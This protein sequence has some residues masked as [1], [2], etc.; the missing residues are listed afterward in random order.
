M[1][2]SE[3]LQPF[4]QMLERCPLFY[5]IPKE[6][7]EPAL[8]CMDAQ[9]CHVKKGQTILTYGD[10]FRYAYYLL[11]GSLNGVFQNEASDQITINQFLPGS[12]MGESF[13]CIE[14]MKSPIELRADCE[15]FLLQLDVHLLYAEGHCHFAYQHA[16]LT[17]LLL[18]L[19]RQNV[20]LNQKVR[21]LS[22]K[23]IRDRFLVYLSILPKSSTGF[24]TV[25]FSRTDLAEY[26]GVNR[27]ALSRELTLME[28]ENVI[29]I[30]GRRIKVLE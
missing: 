14:G 28:K 12:L 25:P 18:A 5:N 1:S 3:D 7:Y 24:V 6:Q 19:A 22:Q 29:E 27:S 8:S 16:L 26:L 4:M 15:S 9:M 20:F 23:G 30:S 17:N 11:E 21:I 13:A 10:S 2:F